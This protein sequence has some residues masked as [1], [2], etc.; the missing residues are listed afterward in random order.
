L[1]LIVILAKAGIHSLYYVN[2]MDP[3]PACRQAGQVGD[4]MIS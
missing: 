3:R 4:D 2:G 1:T